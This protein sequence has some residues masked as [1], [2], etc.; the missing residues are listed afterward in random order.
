MDYNGDQSWSHYLYEPSAMF[1][2]SPGD[3]IPR[4]RKAIGVKKTM[5]TIFFTNKKLLIAEYLPTGQK[6]NQDYFISDILPELEREQ[7]RHQRRKQ[8]GTVTYRWI[9][10][11]S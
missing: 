7:M 2:H 1:A 5:F 10:Q 11:K 3:V 8:G 6:Y 9:T 4:K